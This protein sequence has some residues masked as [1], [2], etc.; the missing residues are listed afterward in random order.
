MRPLPG[1]ITFHRE[2]PLIQNV[3][4]CE[5]AYCVILVVQFTEWNIQYLSLYIVCK[6]VG[7]LIRGSDC[8]RWCTSEF[9]RYFGL[10]KNQYFHYSILFSWAFIHEHLN[11]VILF[12]CDVFLFC[13]N[14]HCRLLF[15]AQTAFLWVIHIFCV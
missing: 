15:L 13:T 1:L 11:I 8:T 14:K 2:L 6:R 9:A 4:F 10:S 5:R 3:L 12:F 7:L